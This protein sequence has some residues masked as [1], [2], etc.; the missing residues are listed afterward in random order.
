MKEYQI[1]SFKTATFAGAA[2]L[3]AIA[4]LFVLSA[5]TATSAAEPAVPS[6]AY[7]APPEET[8][9]LPE[10]TVNVPP[11]TPAVARTEGAVALRVAYRS[12]L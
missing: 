7:K 4:L 8:R 12:W 10:P 9:Q 2:W 3:G 6:P 5:P 1:P 11:A